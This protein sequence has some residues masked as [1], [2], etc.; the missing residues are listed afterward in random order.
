[1]IFNQDFNLRT[2]SCNLIDACSIVFSFQASEL[3]RFAIDNQSVSIY[4][5][6]SNSIIVIRQPLYFLQQRFSSGPVL[7]P[8]S[9]IIPRDEARENISIYQRGKTMIF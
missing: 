9:T 2:L 8:I 5:Y 7:G 6:W 3:V 4:K 1:M